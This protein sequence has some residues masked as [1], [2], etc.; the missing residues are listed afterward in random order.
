MVTPSLPPRTAVK[1]RTEEH[2]AAREL[3]R[4]QSD[5]DQV[6]LSLEC[7]EARL[8]AT[9]CAAALA[10]RA[11]DLEGRLAEA[12]AQLAAAEVTFMCYLRGVGRIQLIRFS[13]VCFS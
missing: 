5:I 6:A 11:A 12:R 13:C 8:A 10:Q 7:G 4:C 2:Q 3:E 9:P 1:R